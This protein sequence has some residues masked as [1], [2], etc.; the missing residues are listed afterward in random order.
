MMCKICL[1]RDLQLVIAPSEYS[2]GY[3]RCKTCGVHSTLAR[4]G[5]DFKSLERAQV[6]HRFNWLGERVYGINSWTRFQFIKSFLQD[7]PGKVLDYGCGRG[8]LLNRFNSQ[9]YKD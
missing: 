1:S 8:D 6:N 3:E 9:R 5:L 4:L 7:N 2:F